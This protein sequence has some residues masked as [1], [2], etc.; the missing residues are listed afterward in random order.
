MNANAHVIDLRPLGPEGRTDQL[1]NGTARFAGLAGSTGLVL[2]RVQRMLNAMCLSP[3]ESD[4]KRAKRSLLLRRLWLRSTRC[5]RYRLRL[6]KLPLREA[7]CFL[8]GFIA[9]PSDHGV[10]AACVSVCDWPPAE[11]VALR[12]WVA[13]FS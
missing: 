2:I 9:L 5:S 4:D 7:R 3:V 10:A 6:F 13:L 8:A 1:S 11:I 12:V